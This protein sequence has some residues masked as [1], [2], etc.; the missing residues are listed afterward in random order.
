MYHTT[1]KSYALKVHIQNPFGPFLKFTFGHSMHPLLFY[2][3]IHVGYKYFFFQIQY[4]SLFT[5]KSLPLTL[6]SVKCK[7]AM[8]HK[9]TQATGLLCVSFLTFVGQL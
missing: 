4:Y 7:L 2:V 9:E 6:F 5:E 3:T 1:Y 8:D